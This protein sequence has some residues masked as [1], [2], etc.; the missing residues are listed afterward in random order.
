MIDKASIDLIN[1]VS[2]E[3]IA[4]VT[5]ISQQ[6][7]RDT[8]DV[9][10][11]EKGE[12]AIKLALLQSLAS[13]ASKEVGLVKE[14]LDELPESDIDAGVTKILLQH[15]QLVY[16]KKRNNDTVSIDAKQLINELAKLE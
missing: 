16:Q 5:K 10:L 2:A 9:D 11:R 12:A 8:N 13:Y 14:T 15:G 7:F 6:I 1:E 4:H 3:I